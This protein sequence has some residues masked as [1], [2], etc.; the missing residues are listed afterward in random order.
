MFTLEEIN[1]EIS[2]LNKY[3]K[4][5]VPQIISFEYIDTNEFYGQVKREEITNNDYIIHFSNCL[6]D[7]VQQYQKSVIWHEATHIHDI[8]EI[9]NKYPDKDISSIIASYSEAH[10][11][12]IQLRYLLKLNSSEIIDQKKRYLP[13]KTNNKDVLGNITANYINQSVQYIKNFIIS[14]NPKDFKSFINNYCY[15]CG[16]IRLKKK[17]DTDK[18]VDYV[19]KLFPYKYQKQLLELCEDIYTNNYLGCGITY[20]EMLSDAITYSMNI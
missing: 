16:Y 5:N 1:D 2:K 11:T 17:T 14:K 18:L 3:L 6:D 4:Y 20:S 10:A 19:H 8:I 7:C 9:K 15:F 12:E 13:Y